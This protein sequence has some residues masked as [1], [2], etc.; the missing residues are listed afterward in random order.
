MGLAE[1][2]LRSPRP[3]ASDSQ[4]LVPRPPAGAA[5]AEAA[6]VWAPAWELCPCFCGRELPPA[7][8]GIHLQFGSLPSWGGPAHARRPGCG[9]GDGAAGGRCDPRPGRAAGVPRLRAP[10]GVP[11]GAQPA[12][13]LQRHGTGREGRPGGRVG[14][15]RD[16]REYRPDSGAGVG[17]GRVLRSLCG[18]PLLAAADGGFRMIP[19][20]R[21]GAVGV[22]GRLERG[23]P[24]A[25]HSPGLFSTSPQPPSPGQDR[26]HG[27]C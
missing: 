20:Q 5:H 19:L 6:A 17:F 23:P 10:L 4:R 26:A 22:T 16:P 11:A 24:A 18:E 1:G 14:A 27:L 8:G 7:D 3:E 21:Q 9:D 25:P 2:H 12:Q 15:D 13:L